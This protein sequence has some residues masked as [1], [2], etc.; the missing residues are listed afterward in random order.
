MSAC[1]PTLPTLAPIKSAAIRGTTRDVTSALTHRVQIELDGSQS[2]RRYSAV[3]VWMAIQ[4]LQESGHR[5]AP[6]GNDTITP[7]VMPRVVK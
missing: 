2:R 6:S 7:S 1:G 4:K 5:E 3:S